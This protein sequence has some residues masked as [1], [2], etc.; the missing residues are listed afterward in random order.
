MEE[1]KSIPWIAFHVAT[2]HIWG[3]TRPGP[4][5]R[6]ILC[7]PFPKGLVRDELA[8]VISPPGSQVTLG[9][10][11]CP[12]SGCANA[13]PELLHWGHQ[14]RGSEKHKRLGALRSMTRWDSSVGREACSQAWW[15]ELGSGDP[16]GRGENQ[17]LWLSYDTHMQCLRFHTHPHNNKLKKKQTISTV[18]AQQLEN[19]H[20]RV[21][22]SGYD[23]VG[24]HS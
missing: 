13:F 11:F 23:G 7:I 2:A 17:I 1:R 9:G 3:L 14:C 5:P 16:H 24:L 18:L 12:T 4:R 6:P 15:L 22:K 19:S 21:W 8:D 20:R 10:G